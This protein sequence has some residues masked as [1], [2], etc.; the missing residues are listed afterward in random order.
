MPAHVY[1]SNAVRAGT[2]DFVSGSFATF[3]TTSTPLQR[4]T[5]SSTV[6]ASYTHRRV[7]I[8]VDGVYAPSEFDPQPFFVVLLSSSHSDADFVSADDAIWFVEEEDS[9]LQHI[10]ALSVKVEKVIV[11]V[12]T[13]II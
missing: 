11:E 6:S 12:N 9:R 5:S 1:S 2:M 8:A 4:Q 10:S 13:F 7:L 3:S